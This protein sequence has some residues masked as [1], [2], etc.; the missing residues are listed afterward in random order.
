[1]KTNELVTALLA[2]MLAAG[3]AAAGAAQKSTTTREEPHKSA[4]CGSMGKAAKTAQGEDAAVKERSPG[5]SELGRKA[6]CPVTGE[7]F[8][9]TKNTPS[10][11]YKGHI[12]YFCCGDCVRSF[13]ADPRKYAVKAGP[14]GKKTAAPDKPGRTALYVCPMGHY[15]SSKPGKCPKC[16]MQLVRKK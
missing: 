15:S 14:K 2:M 16:G 7:K 12:Y 8:K 13:N 10:V 5:K 4:L 6:V 9:V 11:S 3:P 1:M